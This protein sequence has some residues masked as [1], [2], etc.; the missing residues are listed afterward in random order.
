MKC[1][2]CGYEFPENQIHDSHDIP[3]YMGEQ[4]KTVSTGYVK[5]VIKIMKK[6]LPKQ[7]L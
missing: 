5:S 1:D 6:K 3:K 2:K 4:I 7:P